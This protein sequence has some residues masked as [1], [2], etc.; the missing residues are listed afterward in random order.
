MMNYLL[1]DSELIAIFNA[2]INNNMG[3]YYLSLRHIIINDNI[4]EINRGYNLNKLEETIVDVPI[5][6]KKSDA[7]NN[8]GIDELINEIAKRIKDI[9]NV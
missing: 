9:D 8:V 5:Q 1:K 6:N 7:N 4:F 3:V 2:I